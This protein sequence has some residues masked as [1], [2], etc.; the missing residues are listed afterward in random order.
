MLG[1]RQGGR[2]AD[3]LIILQM[4]DNA[5]L[6]SDTEAYKAFLVFLNVTAF[7]KLLDRRS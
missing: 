6:A 1:N 3:V 4:P 7:E 2:H 5:A